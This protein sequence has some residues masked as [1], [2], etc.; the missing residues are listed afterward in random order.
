MRV[1]LKMVGRP[2]FSGDADPDYASFDLAHHPRTGDSR[3][4][5]R[6]SKT[7]TVSTGAHQNAALPGSMVWGSGGPGLPKPGISRYSSCSA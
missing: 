6:H 3:N 5:E 2:P 1:A 4:R 7:G